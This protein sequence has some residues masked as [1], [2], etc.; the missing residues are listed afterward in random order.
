MLDIQFDL[1]IGLHTIK[2]CNLIT[3]TFAYLFSSGM[4]PVH[5]NLVS[6]VEPAGRTHTTHP[7]AVLAGLMR[8]ADLDSMN[9]PT[10]VGKLDLLQQTDPDSEELRN[11]GMKPL[12]Q[13]KVMY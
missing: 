5:A 1:I 2:S 11:P 6:P 10:R 3:K 9:L 12:F 13:R 7:N 8:S 4:I